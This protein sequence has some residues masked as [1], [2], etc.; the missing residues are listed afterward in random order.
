MHLFVLEHVNMGISVEMTIFEGKLEEC[1]VIRV[2]KS[3]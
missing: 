1:R 2:H 3:S